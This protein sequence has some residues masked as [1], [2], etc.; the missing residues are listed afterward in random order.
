[1]SNV[2]SWCK[3]CGEVDLPSELQD[4]EDAIHHHQGLYEHITAAYSEVTSCFIYLYDLYT[5]KKNGVFLQDYFALKGRTLEI[6]LECISKVRIG[7]AK[8]RNSIFIPTKGSLVWLISCKFS[9]VHS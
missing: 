5:S 7:F 8:L 1:M 9:Q 6:K 3:A 4:L 2:D